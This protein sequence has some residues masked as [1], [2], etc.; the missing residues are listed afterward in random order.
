[1]KL[2]VSQLLK[3]NI[4]TR[5][6]REDVPAGMKALKDTW[7]SR[8]KRLPDGTPS[9]SKARFYV[10]GDLQTKGV[11]FFEIYAHAVQ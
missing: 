11:D 6:P 3:Q 10:R 4:R 8:L 5:I 1:M 9:K 2:E 7:V